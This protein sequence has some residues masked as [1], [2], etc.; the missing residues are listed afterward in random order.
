[1]NSYHDPNVTAVC[2]VINS[3]VQVSPVDLQQV[4]VGPGDWSVTP[5]TLLTLATTLPQLPEHC[6]AFQFE[7][8]ICQRLH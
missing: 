6:M 1:M 5:L 8:R 2:R 7:L 4:F 3:C